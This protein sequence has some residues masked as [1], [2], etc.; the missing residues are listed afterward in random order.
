MNINHLKFCGNPLH[1]IFNV[2]PSFQNL[3]TTFVVKI[4]FN[5]INK[6]CIQPATNVKSH[7]FSK[8]ILSSTILYTGFHYFKKKSQLVLLLP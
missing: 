5:W 3:G 7:Q 4:W 2:I 8:S 6:T 1:T